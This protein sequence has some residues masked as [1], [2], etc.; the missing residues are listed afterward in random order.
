MRRKINKIASF[1]LAIWIVL[2][3]FL[4]LAHFKSLYYPFYQTNELK[5][6]L[7]ESHNFIFCNGEEPIELGEKEVSHLIDVKILFQFLKAIWALLLLLVFG[8]NRKLKIGKVRT[9]VYLLIISLLSLII[10]PFF[11]FFFSNVHKLFFKNQSWI[12]PVD[13]LILQ[14]FPM[15]YFKT[16]FIILISISLLIGLILVLFKKNQ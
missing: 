13:S 8:I 14:V 10:I 16:F 12:F 15:I 6:V 7:E 1:L 5:P 11:N 4:V 3:V 9:G 2:T